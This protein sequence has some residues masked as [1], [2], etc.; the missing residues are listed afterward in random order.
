[1]KFYLN[2]SLI[3]LGF[4]C[5]YPSFSQQT[6]NVKIANEIKEVEALF[7]HLLNSKGAAI[8]FFQFAAPD[9]VIKRGE[10]DTL[11]F[12][13]EAIRAYYLKNST[14]GAKATW[15]PER[16]LVSED[17]TMASSYGHY[18]W[19]IPVPNGKPIIAEGVFHT[20]WK[21]QPDGSWKYI[22]D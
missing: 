19:E 6:N 2:L 10:E 21:R 7:Q 12:G 18:K 13:P 15:A 22:W 11:I 4:L 1:M 14:P 9:A 5:S 20:V 8:A 17:G 16:I 3:L